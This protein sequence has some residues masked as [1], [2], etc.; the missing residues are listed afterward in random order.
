MAF[1]KEKKEQVYRKLFSN[2]INGD[3]ISKARENVDISKDEVT[4]ICKRLSKQGCIFLTTGDKGRTFVNFT[5]K[6][7]ELLSEYFNVSKT[8]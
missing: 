1:S 2:F 8:L 6:G 4:N 3:Y 7:K 5:N